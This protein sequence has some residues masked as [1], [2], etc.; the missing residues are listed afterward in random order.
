M[1]DADLDSAAKAVAEGAFLTAGQRCTSTSRV[2]VHI[3][4]YD[5]FMGKLLEETKKMKLGLAFEHDMKIGPVI[6]RPNF[7]NIMVAIEAAKK[8]GAKIIQGGNVPKDGKFVSGNFIEPT[9]ITEL[10]PYSKLASEELLGPVLTVFKIGELEEA[11]EKINVSEYG[12]VASIYTS[13]LKSA[14]LA[15]ENI[16]VGCCYINIPT[17]GVEPHFPC[18][19]IKNSGYGSRGQGM[20]AID[21][22]SEWRTIYLDYN[23]RNAQLPPKSRL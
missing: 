16:K 2:F 13:S 19:G 9:I 11:I 3:A 7:N 17:I 4:V 5:A 20:R 14:M 23:I 1:D 18:A 21:V 22:F 15:S 6:N 8:A 12:L 10:D